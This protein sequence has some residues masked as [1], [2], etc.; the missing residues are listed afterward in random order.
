MGKADDPSAGPS[1]PGVP[2]PA[3]L[4]TPEQA[5]RRALELKDEVTEL[6]SWAVR[7]REVH[8]ELDRMKSFW[9]KEFE[10]PDHPDRALRERL[11]D[12]WNTV[13]DRLEKEVDGLS[14][15]GI[16]VKD[17]DAGL[18]DFYALVEGEVVFLC[19]R[20]GEEEVTFFHSLDGGFRNRRPL[21]HRPTRASPHSRGAP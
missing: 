21:P 18:L 13:H 9:G 17:L 5:G 3:R 7:L 1:E 2:N 15:E 14:K 11:V 20:L 4:W 6:K 12:E 8:A 10:A 19:W 16:E